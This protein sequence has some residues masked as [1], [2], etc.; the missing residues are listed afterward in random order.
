RDTAPAFDPSD[1]AAKQ[2]ADF[3]AP[4]GVGEQL[5]AALIE[6]ARAARIADDFARL[7]AGF[8][9]AF[10]YSPLNLGSSAP[11]MLV[12]PTGAGKTSCAAKLAAASIARSGA[13]LIMTADGGRAGAVDQL[14]TYSE[15]LGSDYFVVE[16]P[17]DI[18]DAIRSI[19]PKG[20]VILDTPGVSPYDS[21][22]LA[23]L[24][25]FQE[26]AGAEAV[27]VLPA[28]GDP[29]E[30]RDWALAFREFGV[31]R[32]IITKFDATKRVG[33]ALNA[34]HAARMALA[35]V[36][37]TAFISEG[38]LEATPEFLARRL[39]ASRPGRVG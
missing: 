20:A 17:G 13:A 31:R 18:E 34:V 11:I 30:F 12:G 39:L 21:G 24:K 10:A 35:Q 3:L 26:T 6:G 14:R 1:G 36:S 15:S 27:L 23:A 28:S 29:A 16:T 38:L 8:Q 2:M 25:S 5:T 7:E 33:A 32:A 4:H 19:R 22:D 9:T 37:E